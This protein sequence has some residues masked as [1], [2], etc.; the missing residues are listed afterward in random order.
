MDFFTYISKLLCSINF[1]Y[2]SL[3]GVISALLFIKKTNS[4]IK[5]RTFNILVA[6]PPLPSAYIR[7]S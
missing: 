4:K 7:P 6:P 3:H 5:K 2:G 1:Y